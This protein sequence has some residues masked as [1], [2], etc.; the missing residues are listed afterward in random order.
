MNNGYI[1]GRLLCR[2]CFRGS[3]DTL[4]LGDWRLQNNPAYYGS[5][6]PKILI[7]GFSKGANQNKAAEGGNFDKIAFANARHRLQEILEILDIMPKDR[8]IDTLMTAH[9]KTFGIASLVRCSFAKM[10]GGTYKTSGY[11]IPSAFTNS[12]TVKIIATCSTKYL[13]ILPKSIRLIILLGTSETYIKKTQTLIA[14]LYSDFTP[15]NQV[16]F[17]AGGALW[18]YATH[19][20]PGNGYFNAWI[21]N[22]RDDKSGLKRIL[23][24][25]A[26]SEYYR[27]AGLSKR[28]N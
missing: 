15:E 4:L 28:R 25:Q 6:S 1:H 21:R 10:V 20:S 24:Q 18:V 16:S 23:T 19:P 2:E 22:G 5:S 11:V 9:E 17:K 8:G 14:Q 7:L 12:E 3:E 26:I 13:G 27:K